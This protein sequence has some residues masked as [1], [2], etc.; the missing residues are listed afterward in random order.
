MENESKVL[1]LLSVPTNR[2]I[3]QKLSERPKTV[4]ELFS[5]LKKDPRIT[6]KN[7][8]SV[9]KDLEKMRLSGILS[10]S[11]DETQKNLYYSVKLKSVLI[12]LRTGEV[13]FA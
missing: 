4:M 11:Y 13:L 1:N 8:E 3:L 5:E 2:I 12:D 7:R 9:Y 10:K 6:I